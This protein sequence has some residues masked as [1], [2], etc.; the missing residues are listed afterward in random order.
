MTTRNSQAL[1]HFVRRVER[2]VCL[3]IPIAPEVLACTLGLDVHEV[4]GARFA[5]RLRA[6][7]GGVITVDPT[8]P[9]IVSDVFVARACASYLLRRSGLIKSELDVG[10]L[11]AALCYDDSGQP[12]RLFDAA[13]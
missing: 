11:A 2:T 8:A 9:P 6:S 1:K 10:A 4:P 3:R 13:E 12:I 5:L 7:H